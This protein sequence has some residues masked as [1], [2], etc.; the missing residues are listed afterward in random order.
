[1]SAKIDFSKRGYTLLESEYVNNKTKMR[2]RCS[3]HKDKEV[4]ISLD[5]LLRGYG[6]PYCA[7]V[8][9]DFEDIIKEFTS[10]GYT[11]LATEY[12]NNRQKLEYICH[13]HPNKVRK[14]A[15]SHFSMGEGCYECGLET[16]GELKRNDLD[17][18]KR[19]FESKGFNL[20][21]DKYVNDITKM[22]YTCS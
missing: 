17:K 4:S 1:E 16:I 14:I 20:L 5:N 9:V 19:I 8:K 7:K 10:R 2:Y 3:A 15:Y 6:C 11:L 18:V 22:K 21:E 13:R 12:K